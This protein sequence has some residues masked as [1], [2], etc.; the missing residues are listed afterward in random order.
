MTDAYC[1]MIHGGLSLRFIETKTMASQCCLLSNNF[2]IDLSTNFWS[3]KK[4]QILRSMNLENKWFSGCNN[5]QKLENANQ[6]SFRTGM[7]EGLN[8]YHQSELSGPARIDLMF[9]ISCNLACRTCNAASSTYW[10]KHLKQHN[11]WDKPVFSSKNKDTVIAALKQLDLSNLKMLVFAGGE[12]LLGQEYWDVA[13]WLAD[14][15][16]NAKQQ[17]TLCFQTNGTQPI[18]PRNH[19]LID[20]FHLVKLHI[21]L[22]GTKEKF[23][24]LRWPASWNQVTENIL[25]M[26]E[27]LPSNV[28]FLIE[29]TV[30]IFNL[31][32]V[33]ELEDWTTNNFST[34]REGDLVVHSKHLAR[35]IFNLSNC[36][37]EYV[38]AMQDRV[39]KNLIN[40]SWTENP[41]AVSSMINEIKKF[42]KFRNQSFEQT[43][44]EV[45]QFYAR[46]L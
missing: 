20:K 36:T 14:N 32:Y 13:G 9:D 44:P 5:C 16:P 30:S 10:Q 34:N 35:G 46:Y 39:Y 8:L 19:A 41:A 25:S 3:D 26:R 22:D 15:V 12:T 6:P 42:D 23:E 4:F 43:F 38:D 7:N 40:N 24:Y 11:L 27:S 28:M 37:Q 18:H 21:S 29:E 45:S 1:S 17:L 33:H 31:L 2:K